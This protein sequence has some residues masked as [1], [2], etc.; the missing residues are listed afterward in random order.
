MMKKV[1]INSFLLVALSPK[2]A[3][4]NFG[5]VYYKGRDNCYGLN[6]AFCFNQFPPVWDQHTFDMFV[7]DIVGRCWDINSD[8]DTCSRIQECVDPCD[9]RLNFCEALVHRDYQSEICSNLDCLGG[10]QCL[11]STAHGL[12]VGFAF[13][14][15][16]PQL[17]GE[18]EASGDPHFK[19]W[20][21][22]WY[23]KFTV[24]STSRMCSGG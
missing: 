23:G 17:E 10:Q 9:E 21:G 6:G 16:E 12:P 7:G 4:A 8:M 15:S 24:H 1:A 11:D 20:S 5:E 22:A 3:Q 14:A 18:A 2:L 13:P 19:T